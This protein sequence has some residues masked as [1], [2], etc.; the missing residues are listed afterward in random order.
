MNLRDLEYVV[1]IADLGSFGRAAERCHVSQPTLSSQVKKL[2]GHLGVQLFERTSK[3]VMLTEIG[4]EIVTV[5]RRVLTETERIEHLAEAAKDPFRGDLRLGAI[6]TVAAYLLPDLV[7]RVDEEL[8]EVRIILMEEKTDGLLTAIRDGQLDAGIVAL[9]VD[10]EGLSSEVLFEDPFLLAISDRD[11]SIDHDTVTLRELEGRQ[12]MLLEEG[13]CLRDQA[14]E[15][16]R[17]Q[18]WGEEADFRATSMETLRQMVRAGTGITLIP[19]LAI[20]P[21]PGIRYI[22]F[23]GEAPGRTLALLWRKTSPR[24]ALIRTVAELLAE[25]HANRGR[26]E[27]ASGPSPVPGRKTGLETGIDGILER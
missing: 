15:L 17:A 8:P 6:P 20:R 5:A 21:E 12:L 13:H 23:D 3:R 22:P 27:Q 4:A 24:T 25:A 18:E 11:R 19:E 26:Q 10:D 9:P 16:C 7:A 1:A 14:L 2:E